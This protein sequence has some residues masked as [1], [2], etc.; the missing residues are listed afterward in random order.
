MS[1]QNKKASPLGCL[2][3]FIIFLIF[4]VT[5]FS[6]ALGTFSIVPV[7]FV[8]IQV[9][10]FYGIFKTIFT[11]IKK[12]KEVQNQ[13]KQPAQPPQTEHQRETPNQNYEYETYEESETT[14]QTP[15]ITMEVQ[16]AFLILGLS[17]N[18]SY[19]KVSEKYY[20]LTKKINSKKMDEKTRQQQLDEINKAYEVL[21]DYYSKMG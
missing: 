16:K 10:F 5:F 2:V 12:A 7:L 9:L 11:I 4:L 1:E 17:P 20:E 18:V 6:P 14:Q 21:T 3:G 15:Q 8:L 13:T 19:T